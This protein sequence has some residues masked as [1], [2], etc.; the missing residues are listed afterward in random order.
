MRNPIWMAAAVV[1]AG[2]AHAAIVTETLL[3]A[4]SVANFVYQN[5]PYS[6]QMARESNGGVSAQA[7]A[8][9]QNTPEARTASRVNAGEMAANARLDGKQLFTIST[10]DT[11]QSVVFY[12]ATF[13]KVSGTSE[14]FYLDFYLPPSYVETTT[15]SEFPNARVDAAIAAYI[16]VARCTSFSNC[17]LPVDSFH[18]SAFLTDTYRT[19][20]G[21]G[22]ATGQAGMDLSSLQGGTLTDTYDSTHFL[23]T[24]NLSFP[25]YAGTL[26]LGTVETGEFVRFKYTMNARSTGSSTFSVGIASI[27]DPFFLDSD[28]VRS[29]VPVVLRSDATSEVPEPGALWLVAA[30]MAALAAG[31]LGYANRNG[32]GERFASPLERRG[33]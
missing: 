13:A 24:A 27:N 33:R 31:K 3:H 30:G 28:P 4:D 9:N 16:E 2:T 19:T 14:H 17:D 5:V 25:G 15:N 18:F 21:S 22:Q 7:L 12:Q 29:G 8:G 11:N 1:C 20:Y 32:R 23:R 10:I 26:D 6:A